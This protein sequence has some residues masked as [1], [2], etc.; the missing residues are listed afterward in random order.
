LAGTTAVPAV[1]AGP[2][3]DRAS[4]ASPAVAA[5]AAC[6]AG[7]KE[8]SGVAAC[9]TLSA[10]ANRRGSAVAAGTAGAEQ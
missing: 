9:P 8:E 5:V 3:A 7:A 4:G 2:A 10:V 1:A 6:P